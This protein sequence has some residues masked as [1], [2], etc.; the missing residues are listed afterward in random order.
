MSKHSEHSFE[1]AIEYGLIQNSGYA[2]RGPENYDEERALF[3]KD[4]C[5]FLRE[6]QP[7]KWSAL[8]TLLAGRTEATVIE[9]LVKE[10]EA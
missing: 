6:N 8:E 7:G 1:T 10:M 5:G 4:V 2:K 9:N 3:P